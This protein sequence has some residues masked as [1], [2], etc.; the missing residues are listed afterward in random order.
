MT[1]KQ[2]FK[3]RDAS[4]YDNVVDRFDRLT[5]QY[6]TYVIDTLLKELGPTP[7]AQIVDIGCGSGVVALNAAKKFGNSSKIIGIDL[8][9]GMLAFARSKAEDLG[10]SALTKFLKC[11]AENL[12][13]ADSS[14]DAVVS[15]Y[16][17]RHFPNP[18]KAVREVNRILKP[19]GRFVAAVGS[20]PS[21]FTH[22]GF[23]AALAVLPRVIAKV[24][25]R[26]LTAC[27][28]LESLIGTHLSE[29][30]E[31]EVAAWTE[32]HHGFSGSMAS[33]AQQAGFEV[34][35]NTWKGHQFVIPSKEEFWELQTTFSSIARKR[36]EHASPLELSSLK[37]AFFQDCDSVLTRG[38]KLIYRVGAAIIS[39]SKQR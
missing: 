37:E 5:E 9:D 39:A 32:H 3:T 25:G 36:L 38:G 34:Q 27:D 11:D 18:N 15:L 31:E 28:H 19:G 12:T 33:L 35:S 22:D 2:D 4:S 6:S 14:V 29:A 13:L 26:Q 1:S 17:F 7:V 8:S 30:T 23:L 21:L 20:G 16:A 10:L 24:T